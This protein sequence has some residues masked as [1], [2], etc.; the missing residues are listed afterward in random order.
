MTRRSRVHGHLRV[1]WHSHEGTVGGLVGHHLAT[2]ARG[3]RIHE[4]GPTLTAS[5]TYMLYAGTH[6][7][8]LHRDLLREVG[9][10]LWLGTIHVRMH[11]TR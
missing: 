9:H 10:G 5:K 11:G 1:R 3:R 4:L 8:V 2:H 7:I 6:A